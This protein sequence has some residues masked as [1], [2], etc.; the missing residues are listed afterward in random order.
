M[1]KIIFIMCVGIFLHAGIT[2]FKIIDKATKAYEEK[3][4]TKSAS[5]LKSLEK[6]S[7]KRV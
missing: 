2:D 6:K 1:M 5:L 7:S 3:A 4:Y